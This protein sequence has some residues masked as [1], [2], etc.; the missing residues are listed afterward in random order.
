[1]RFQRNTSTKRTLLS[2][3]VT[4]V[5]L[6]WSSLLLCQDLRQYQLDK[7]R[8][9]F[10][11]K[12]DPSPCN[13]GSIIVLFCRIRTAIE[14]NEEE[15]IYHSHFLP[16]FFLI[17]KS[18]ILLLTPFSGLIDTLLHSCQ[19]E[20]SFHK[21]LWHGDKGSWYRIISIGYQ[22]WPELWTFIALF[23]Q[24]KRLR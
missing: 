12:S 9:L 11:S 15:E 7:I 21:Y 1:M 14:V 4:T 20:G 17:Y 23:R 19:L 6:N 5:I 10:I 18:C 22:R 8:K 13:T 24:G 16:L 3:A 2:L